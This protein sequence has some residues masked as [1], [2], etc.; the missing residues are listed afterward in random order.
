M[1]IIDYNGQQYD[2]PDGTPDT[3][4]FEFLQNQPDP[5]V[6]GESAV[7]RQPPVDESQ[8]DYGP[9]S[10]DDSF[11][12][13]QR[14]AGGPTPGESLT[15]PNNASAAYET[16][17]GVVD[18]LGTIT[19]LPIEAITAFGRLGGYEGLK[20]GDGIRAYKQFLNDHGF[21]QGNID[22]LAGKFGE[23][24]TWNLILTGASTM[25]GKK[26]MGKFIDPV[27]KKLIP[28]EQ[29]PGSQL[30]RYKIGRA[31]GSNPG[32]QLAAAAG[33]SAS[34]AYVEDMQGENPATAM[35]GYLPGA[36][37]TSMAG[38]RLAGIWEYATR[39]NATDA[40]AKPFPNKSLPAGTQTADL[41]APK[42]AA[43]DALARDLA[44]QDNLIEQSVE[45]VK[46]QHWAG[47]R[48]WKTD[49]A[50]NPVSRLSNAQS[51]AA[52][53]AERDYAENTM[54]QIERTHWDNATKGNPI[55]TDPLK[56]RVAA[57]KEDMLQTRYEDHIPEKFFE[58]IENWE[59][60]VRTEKVW[61]TISALYAERKR[62]YKYNSDFA[63]DK[64]IYA[65]NLDRLEGLLRESL[66]SAIDDPKALAKARHWTSARKQRF[67]DGPMGEA[68][69]MEGQ[70][71][72]VST[73]PLTGKVETIEFGRGNAAPLVAGTKGGPQQIAAT[74]KLFDRLG[75]TTT[76]SDDFENA[77]KTDFI[78]QTMK[79][80]PMTGAREP[81]MAAMDKFMKQ[82]EASLKPYKSLLNELQTHIAYV[83]KQLDEKREIAKGVYA[84]VAGATEGTMQTRVANA[85]FH[86]DAEKR[87]QQLT[88]AFTFDD[89]GKPLPS[90][91]DYVEAWETL[92]VNT[93]MRRAGNTAEGMQK[94]I[95]SPEWKKLLK[96][97]FH[98]NPD[99]LERLYH[100]VDLGVN[101]QRDGVKG[102]L[103]GLA[104]NQAVFWSGI[105]GAK[106][107]T[108]FNS[109]SIQ[110]PGYFARTGRNIVS[111][112]MNRWMPQPPGEKLY[113]AISTPE[114]Y[115]WMTKN[116][117]EGAPGLRKAVRQ[118]RRVMALMN[119]QTHEKMRQWMD[120]WGIRPREETAP[121]PSDG[122]TNF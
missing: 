36:G 35:V 17:R 20:A 82:H 54:R 58:R 73:N 7:N 2:F 116:V 79:V 37:L 33:G 47:L 51:N 27:T 26:M 91:H 77:I 103:S 34:Q 3:E 10:Y 93:A 114:G 87:V 16:A 61:D 6:D 96:T 94:L 100:A 15:N 115:N 31:L 1:P 84:H 109:G 24:L 63:G 50:G 72:S 120:E 85:F 110:V 4:I 29:V 71:H 25:V 46:A 86:P 119:T 67:S 88:R 98:R 106:L 118:G 41:L 18:T 56:V 42:V 95:N 97:A 14:R 60:A 40:I 39:K 121:K 32:E 69:Y 75:I 48:P 122:W 92:V 66:E 113:W 76:L 104:R 22:T 8:L 68:R 30:G 89:A 53:E 59:P 44:M 83:R 9:Y 45:G 49:A 52:F 105:F 99:K 5:I 13:T 38:R 19:G 23:D 55:E 101:L 64:A 111:Q 102:D 70:G 62:I 78:E 112:F 74:Q 107:G 57:L 81:D 43:E 12:G 65:G 117:Y 90:N 21:P 108:A 11:G 80:N 28:E